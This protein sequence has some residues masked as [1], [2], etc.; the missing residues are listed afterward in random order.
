MVVLNAV[1]G[2]TPRKG[3]TCFIFLLRA[4]QA[5][6]TNES[7]AWLDG[8][9][10]LDAPDISLADE[11]RLLTGAQSLSPIGLTLLGADEYGVDYVR[12]G[13]RGRTVFKAGPFLAE[14]AAA[15]LARLLPDL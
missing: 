1:T 3:D 15:E 12:E 9:Q 13:I 7:H 14:A 6:S 11:A 10:L 4:K 2:Q 5:L 8:K